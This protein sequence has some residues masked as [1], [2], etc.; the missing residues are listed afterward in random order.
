MVKDIPVHNRTAIAGS[1][2]CWCLSGWA[3]AGDRDEDATLESADAAC[4]WAGST[5]RGICASPFDSRNQRNEALAIVQRAFRQEKRPIQGNNTRIGSES[6]TIAR[7]S[8]CAF[9]QENLLWRAYKSH[10]FTCRCVELPGCSGVDSCKNL[11]KLSFL[12]CHFTRLHALNSRDTVDIPC[13]PFIQQNSIQ[14]HR[15]RNSCY[16]GCRWPTAAVTATD[17]E[18]MRRTTPKM[19]KVYRKRNWTERTIEK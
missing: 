6:R 3:V 15:F 4:W 14:A 10:F 16:K 7:A 1:T 19:P 17:T 18:S 11:D 2:C 13:C 8:K 12:V 9:R 5:T